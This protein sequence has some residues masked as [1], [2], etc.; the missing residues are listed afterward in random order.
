MGLKMNQL[1]QWL[2]EGDLRSDGLSNEIV[3]I[4]M[5]EPDLIDDLIEGLDHSDEVVR[6]HTAD[7]LEKIGR[8]RPDLLEGYIP[9]LLDCIQ[10]DSVAMVKMHLAMIIGHL[11]V[12]E[13]RADEFVPALLAL[14]HDERR[15]NV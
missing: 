14:I 6:G 5:Q 2:S 9:K 12:Y 10:T 11:V 8:S 4:V 13:E 1:L 3:K 15:L 7:A